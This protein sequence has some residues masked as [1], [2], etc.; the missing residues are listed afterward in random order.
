MKRI[1]TLI[2]LHTDYSYDSNIS[3]DTLAAF[4]ESESI[5]CVAVTDHDSIEGALA[6][7]HRT[8][9]QVIV[10]EEITTRDG[11]LIGLF[12]ESHIRPGMSAT[13]TAE[14][15]RDQGGLVLLPHPFV[16]IFGCGLREK[17][18]D[19]LHWLDAVEVNNGQNALRRPD[20]AAE[21][22]ADSHG[23]VKYVGADSHMTLSIA[24]CYQ[25]MDSFS[26]PAGFLQSLATAELIRGKH[27]LAFFAAT[28]WRLMRHYL[29]LPLGGDFGVN[30]TRT[31][32]PVQPVT[33]GQ[34]ATPIP[35][36]Q[37]I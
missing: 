2:H 4:V 21:R 35:Q 15:I 1:K 19:I 12:L 36:V 25:Y 5:G 37:R 27:S 29:G 30:T 16:R 17:S 31:S 26:G 10:G 24:P 20:R 13:D 3:L 8:D 18:W 7:R 23:L 28:G 6:L 32:L 14:A 33:T 9:A 11:H 34:P 22:F